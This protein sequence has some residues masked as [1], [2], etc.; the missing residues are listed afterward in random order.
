[1]KRLSAVCALVLGAATLAHAQVDRATL[2]GIV[3]DAQGAQIG[4][5]TVSVTNTATNV[6]VQAKTNA[7]GNY[8]TMALEELAEGKLKYEYRT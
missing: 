1:M 8:L 7:E 4:G 6:S 5:A 3:R 2:S